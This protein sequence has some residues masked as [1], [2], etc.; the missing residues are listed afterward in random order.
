MSAS[1]ADIKMVKRQV[2]VDLTQH[3]M[4]EYGKRLAEVDGQIQGLETAKEETVENYNARIRLAKSERGMFSQLVR[5][6]WEIRP[7][8]VAEVKDFDAKVVRY[9]L[10][11]KEVD[12]RPMTEDDRQV[13][14]PTETH[15]DL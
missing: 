13:E 11:P 6:G 8:D 7:A 1:S 14:I 2:R 9:F 3:E 5:Q 10:G 4:A 15:R 12:Q